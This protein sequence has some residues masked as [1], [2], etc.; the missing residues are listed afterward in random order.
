M[1]QS[2]IVT[3]AS[4]LNQP[5]KCCLVVAVMLLA[6]NLSGLN[7][8][9]ELEVANSRSFE[10]WK[11][12]LSFLAV[13]TP[14]ELIAS[15]LIIAFL[16][17]S[18]QKEINFIGLLRCNCLINVATL[19]LSIACLVL[20][21]SLPLSNEWLFNWLQNQSVCGILPIAFWL[22]FEWTLMIV[23][24]HKD[25]GR[26]KKASFWLPVLTMTAFSYAAYDQIWFLPNFCLSLW[27]N[28]SFANGHQKLSVETIRVELEDTN[29]SIRDELDTGN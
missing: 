28:R 4:S 10:V 26:F 29:E 22:T 5:K 27:E 9:F 11:I 15:L 17:F 2:T 1:I 23:S 25:H 6:V 20:V 24:Q 18:K 13:K 16:L 19:F 7:K 21:A 14:L 8:L 12:A 3:V